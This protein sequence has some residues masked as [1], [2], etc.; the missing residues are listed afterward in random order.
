M[1]VITLVPAGDM[2]WALAG[3]NSAVMTG[4]ATSKH[5]GMINSGCRYPCGCPVTV[6]TDIRALDVSGMLAR[7]CRT[8]MAT[9]TISSHTAVIEPG[10][11]P[12]IRGMTVVAL[13]A[14]GDMV[15]A[16]AG[17]NGAIVA[18]EARA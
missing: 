18:G 7:R 15:W 3:R 8:I 16:L 14:T 12:V 4:K 10:R 6:F 11:T 5:L 17:R 1:A 2:V 13:V 9:H